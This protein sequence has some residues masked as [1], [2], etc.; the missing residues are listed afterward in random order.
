MLHPGYKCCLNKKGQ[1]NAQGDQIC[2]TVFELWYSDLICSKQ[3]STV[4]TE[5]IEITW[6]FLVDLNS[7]ILVVF[8]LVIYL[9]DFT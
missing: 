2:Y 9:E 1:A 3:T 8:A 7:M 4:H 5:R 6:L